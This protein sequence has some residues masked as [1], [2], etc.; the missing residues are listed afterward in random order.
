MK[1]SLKT[2]HPSVS[3]A[4]SMNGMIGKEWK[5]CTIENCYLIHGW[6]TVEDNNILSM[7]DD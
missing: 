3:L 6:Y 2:F 7:N 4:C 5:L 1:K